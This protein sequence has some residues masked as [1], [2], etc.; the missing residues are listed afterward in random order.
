MNPREILI[1][2]CPWA[3]FRVWVGTPVDVRITDA[4]VGSRCAVVG[5]ADGQCD[6][7]PE[8]DAPNSHAMAFGDRD[9]TRGYLDGH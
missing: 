3:P 6:L 9:W 5:I 2:D 4:L 8:S 1:L 7:L